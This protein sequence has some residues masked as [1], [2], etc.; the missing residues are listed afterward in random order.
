[1]ASEFIGLGMAPRRG[2][3]YPYQINSA[4]LKEGAVVMFDASANGQLVKAPTGAAVAGVAGVIADV[5]NVTTGTVIGTDVNLQIDEIGMVILK[6]GLTVAPGDA[7][8]VAGTDGSVRKLDSTTD[9]GAD[10]VG[11][12]QVA[13]TAGATNEMILARIAITR[14]ET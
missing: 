9:D 1:M 12:S 8:V 5:L 3:L 11:Y 7:L 6:N 13:K 2:K 10:I 14:F 4:G